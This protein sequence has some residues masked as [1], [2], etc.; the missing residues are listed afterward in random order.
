MKLVVQVVN[1]SNSALEK[2]CIDDS[3]L[4]I[5]R[6]WSNDIVLQ[7]RYVDPQHL[8]LTIN[9]TTGTLRIEDLHSTNGTR[10][11]GKAL[12]DGLSQYSFGDLIKVGDTKLRIYDA[13]A[14]VAEA[15]TLSVWSQIKPVFDSTFSFIAL[16]LLALAAVYFESYTTSS[17]PLK[18]SQSYE[19]LIQVALLI[20]VWTL[21]IAL[22]SKAVRGETNLR[23]HWSLFCLFV[24]L[25]AVVDLV[26]RI[27]AFNLQSPPLVDLGSTLLHGLIIGLGC[28]AVLSYSTYLSGTA[29]KVFALVMVVAFTVS[30]YSD[31][32]F[33]APHER[34]SALT[35]NETTTLPPGFLLRSPVDLE[36]Y[37]AHLGELFAPYNPELSKGVAN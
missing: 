21:V 31:Q 3:G 2:V 11:G 16:T 20:F 24:V 7:D 4:A 12:L 34:W 28:L 25:S 35:P 9:E 1:N 18:F 36:E 27:V 32:L 33:K 10:V 37:N 8:H 23:V 14:P 15:A 26:L 5:G 17:Q 30:A 19:L 6:D 29:K 22:I 13:D